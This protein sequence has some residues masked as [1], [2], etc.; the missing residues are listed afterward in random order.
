MRD[1]IVAGLTL[2]LI[3]F[4]MVYPAFFRIIGRNEVTKHSR[5]SKYL[6]INY[7][8]HLLAGAVR[9]GLLWSNKVNYPL[10]VAGLVY[11]VVIVVVVVYYWGGKIPKWNLFYA[12]IIFGAIVYIRAI[13]HI[14]QLQPLWSGVL[15]GF[16]SA[17]LLAGS[18]FLMVLVFQNRRIK[19]KTADLDISLISALLALIS[20]R[21]I[22]DL[23]S[24]PTGTVADH[25]GETISIYRLIVQNDFSSFLITLLIGIVSP[26]IILTILRFGWKTIERQ[27]LFLAT[28]S[29]T[30][31]FW[32]T[33]FLFKYFLLQ[34]GIVL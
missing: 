25:Y 23:F 6:H 20:F 2:N 33:E 24:M 1:I 18:F 21:F 32:F 19:Q 27:Q 14:V 4:T 8:F 16:I 28:I 11:F 7:I 15:V 13:R 3:G 9:V 26:I 17:A 5:A 22:W 30:L 29:L 10:Q 31:F 12:S 34:Y